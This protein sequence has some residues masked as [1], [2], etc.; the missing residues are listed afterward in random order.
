MCVCGQ[1]RFSSPVFRLEDLKQ[2]LNNA[3]RLAVLML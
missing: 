1:L 2:M 3:V